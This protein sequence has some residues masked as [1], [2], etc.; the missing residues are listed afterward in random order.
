MYFCCSCHP[1]VTWL[2]ALIL[3]YSI[4]FL[5]NFKALSNLL[6]II[7]LFF[8][9]QKNVHSHTFP[10]L[11]IALHFRLPHYLLK[12]AKSQPIPCHLFSGYH[13]ILTLILSSCPHLSCCLI[14]IY[15]AIAITTRRWILTCS[16]VMCFNVMPTQPSNCILILYY[17]FS[18]Y[19]SWQL[20]TL[21][22]LFLVLSLPSS[23]PVVVVYFVS[24][25]D[26]ILPPHYCFYYP[27]KRNLSPPGFPL[28]V[29]LSLHIF[30]SRSCQNRRQIDGSVCLCSCSF[31]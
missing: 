3:P 24:R 31:R 6:H 13:F 8:S 22:I 11:C 12:L 26:Y 9:P 28:L 14:Y 17:T 4:F 25:L 27:T 23:F 19:G 18:P 20:A 1:F 10:Y 30:F 16:L 21:S 7:F 2:T 15:L 29:L 5:H